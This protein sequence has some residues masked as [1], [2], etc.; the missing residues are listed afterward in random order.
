METNQA[1]IEKF[2]SAFAQLD[3]QSMAECYHED[4]HFSDP[5]FTNLNG[6]EAFAM[7]HMLCTRAKEF[8]LTFDNVWANETQ[9]G[10]NWNAKYLFSKSGKKV[11]NHITAT[12]TFKDG[13]II[14]H[15]DHFDFYKWSCMALGLP[16]ILL[17]WTPFLRNK[18]QQ[19]GMKELHKFMAKNNY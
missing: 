6:K 12:F 1:L 9:G 19:M 2:Y 18:V 15:K 3:Y 5:A 11:D 4:I 7:W 16:G 8:N 17:G 14:D 13:K 10:C